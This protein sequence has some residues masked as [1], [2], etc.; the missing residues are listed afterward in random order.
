MLYQ[1]YVHVFITPDWRRPENPFIADKAYQELGEFQSRIENTD[2][3]DIY[4]LF[5]RFVAH[6]QSENLYEPRLIAHKLYQALHHPDRPEIYLADA[7]CIDEL[8]MFHPWQ[9]A[10]L[11]STL[12]NPR[13][14]FLTLL[15]D[16][17]QSTDAEQ[18]PLI[19]MLTA[20]FQAH[21]FPDVYMGHLSI[22]YRS[23][24]QV[25]KLASLVLEAIKAT[26]GSKER[27]THTLYLN[28][29]APEGR[30]TLSTALESYQTFVARTRLHCV[31][32]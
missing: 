21:H 18:Q 9:W 1:E 10:C 19:R 11:L 29:E 13:Q 17:F 2:R 20:Y 25:T 12:K 22:N 26:Y 23:A 31:D 7:I 14:G 3:S 32:P 5:E 27:E 15:G 30:I 4:A 8:H 28:P 16:S 24:Q 6:C